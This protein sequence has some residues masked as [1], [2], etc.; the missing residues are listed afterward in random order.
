M[1]ARDAAGMLPILGLALAVVAS[2]ALNGSYLLQHAGSRGAP[3]L[4][5]RRPLASFRGLLGSRLWLAGA[6]AGAL[7]SVLHIGALGTAPLSLVQAFTAGGLA[8]TVP[9]AARAFGQ[10]LGRSERLA[11]SVL[12]A[13]LSLLGLGA[14]PLVAHAI[15]AHGLAS[16]SGWPRWRPAAW[17]CRAPAAGA[18]ASWGRPAAFS[19]ARATR[20]PRP[21]P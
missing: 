18:A 6:V 14:G 20:P 7:G 13:A 1:I 17:R 10:R 11:V 5:L 3:A 12:V 9:V 15:P 4:D 21:S 19:T 2:V 8:L 16:R